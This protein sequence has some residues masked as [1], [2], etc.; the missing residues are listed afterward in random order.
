MQKLKRKPLLQPL[1]DTLRSLLRPV[2]GLLDKLTP[3]GK[4]VMMAA[5]IVVFLILCSAL[6]G[7]APR[8]IR[9]TLPPQAE[10]REIPAFEGQ[11]YRDVILYVIELRE[12]AQQSEADKAVI[13]RVYGHD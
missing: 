6:S 11:T 7:C 3:F 13:R 1:G 12:V 8:T 10:P 5:L 2:D 4:P 9:P